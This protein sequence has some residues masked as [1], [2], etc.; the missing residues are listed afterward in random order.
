M[1]PSFEKVLIALIVGM[2]ILVTVRVMLESKHRFHNAL[3][4]V[5]SVIAGVAAGWFSYQWL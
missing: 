4:D 1:E 2:W 5:L 3:A